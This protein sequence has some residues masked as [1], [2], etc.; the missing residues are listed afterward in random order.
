MLT[1]PMKMDLMES[2]K[3]SA[4]KIQMPGNHPKEIIQHSE[5]DETL[6][7]RNVGSSLLYADK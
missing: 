4:H 2:S 5:H 3:M 7:S 1:P 6:K